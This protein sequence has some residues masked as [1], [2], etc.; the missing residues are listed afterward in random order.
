VIRRALPLVL[1]ALLAACGDSAE[2]SRPAGP[3]PA[4]VE[5]STVAPGTIRDTVE[6]VGQLEASESVVLKPETAGIVESVEFEE[7]QEVEKG[8]LLFRLRADEQRARLAEAKAALA[9]AEQVHRRATTL[10]AEKVLSADELDRARSQLAAARARVD[11]AQ[12]ELDRTEIRAPFAGVLGQ[13]LVSPG[14][15]VTAGGFERE[16]SGLVQIDAIAQL[17]LSA[18]VPE[19]AIPLVRV[20][21]PITVSVAPF[22]GE[23]FPGEVY[24]VAPAVTERSRTLLLKAMVPNPDRRLRPGLFANVGVEIAR[25][26]DVLIVPE[27]AIV[28]DAAG[29]W[30]WRLLPDDTAERVAVSLGLRQEGRVEITAGLAAGDR[31]VS[32]G[33]H[34]V[35]P[36]RPLVFESAA[37]KADG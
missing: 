3:P 28:Y 21:M 10:A 36:G 4:A 9:L 14:D 1:V 13:R 16:E 6:L 15:R 37:P 20:G 29:T 11:L 17:K 8:A 19:V 18:P 7:G 32:A 12:V 30:V 31:V 2:S 5:V 24:F 33:T 25:R 27:S 22:P 26:D 23:T 35:A 34:K